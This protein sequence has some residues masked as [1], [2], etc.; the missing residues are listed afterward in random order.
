MKTCQPRSSEDLGN[1]LSKRTTDK[2]GKAADAKDPGATPREPQPQEMP[3]P[4]TKI[5]RR[6]VQEKR[7]TK[8][9]EEFWKGVESLVHSPPWG[10]S[11]KKPNCKQ[12]GDG[13]LEARRKR[14][15]AERE[16]FWKE[17]EDLV[18]SLPYSH[19]IAAA[20]HFD[21][22]GEDSQ[23]ALEIEIDLSLKTLKSRAQLGRIDALKKLVAIGNEIAEF[24]EEP[25]GGDQEPGPDR[26][27]HDTEIFRRRKNGAALAEV[28]PE[29]PEHQDINRIQDELF[30]LID[31]E[32]QRDDEE[33]H[34]TSKVAKTLYPGPVPGFG[35]S[36]ASMTG[37]D[38]FGWIKTLGTG[39]CYL[40]LCDRIL[41]I[42]QI[43]GRMVAE[44]IERFARQ[45][46]LHV[47][48]TSTAWPVAASHLREARSMHV[49]DV[50]QAIDLGGRLEVRKIP[51]PKR[52]R[53]RKGDSSANTG[54]TLEWV[55]LINRIRHGDPD[56]S[57]FTRMPVYEDI[58]ELSLTQASSPINP[59]AKPLV[60]KPTRQEIPKRR[61]HEFAKPPS[62]SGNPEIRPSG[63]KPNESDWIKKCR[64]LPELSRENDAIK[65]WRAH[66]LEGLAIVYRGN[67]KDVTWPKSVQNRI[68]SK[69]AGIKS[70]ERHRTPRE[71]VTEAIEAG[72]KQLAPRVP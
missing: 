56:I 49:E 32:L 4:L 55:D 41:F 7:D 45:A 43:A 34:V 62:D 3:D 13:R 22:T 44:R 23:A 17:I 47:A 29:E 63:R 42:E 67:W 19:L 12:A 25:P 65:K 15:N 58:P 59:A 11:P 14:D 36:A 40:D 54:F 24:L 69:P 28:A 50:A 70:R 10:H 2:P 8:E 72:L 39:G 37:R 16:N 48:G 1:N 57:N 31:L 27:P 68:D 21:G 20:D 66:I 53:P 33:F 35:L 38:E 9:R 61:T 30:E 52:G 60:A 46:F 64:H 51:K 6:Q 26:F 18:Q 71:V 5:P